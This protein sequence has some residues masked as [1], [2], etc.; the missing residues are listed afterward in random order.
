[1]PSIFPE[2]LNYSHLAPFILRVS[3]AIVLLRMVYLNFKKQEK[4]PK[5][6][7]AIQALSAGLLL[8]GFLTQAAALLTII[9]VIAGALRSKIKNL[10]IDEK[11]LKF[12]ILGV[13]L[14][15]ILLGSGLFSFDL[16]L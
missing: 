2:L 11:A 12:L 14:S 13:A 4:C 5:I 3:L 6:C 16:P 9:V 8:V 7:T 1:M 15:L 10:P